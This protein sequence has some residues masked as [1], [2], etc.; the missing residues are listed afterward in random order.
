MSMQQRIKVAFLRLITHISPGRGGNLTAA[1]LP[2]AH[3]LTRDLRQVWYKHVD[4][5]R[6]LKEAS[7]PRWTVT[8]DGRPIQTPARVPLALPTESMAVAIAMEWQAQGK[9]LQAHTMPLMKLATTSIDQIPTIRPTM[10]SSMLRT[11]ETDVTCM[12]V[13]PVEEPVRGQAV[14]RALAACAWRAQDVGHAYFFLEFSAPQPDDCLGERM[15]KIHSNSLCRDQTARAWSF[16]GRGLWPYLAP[17]A[18]AGL[19]PTVT[20]PRP[21]I[22]PVGLPFFPGVVR[23][24]GRNLRP[25]ARLAGEG[26]R[27]GAHPHQRSCRRAL[28]LGKTKGRRPTPLPRRMDRFRA[29]HALWLVQVAGACTGGVARQDRRGGGVCGC[30]ASGAAPSRGMGG[31]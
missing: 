15:R 6:M 22:G 16:L 8:L 29:R 1:H 23:Q 26:R 27:R 14:S 17:P 20:D 10:H 2:P 21:P 18:H 24:G 13:E 31:G 12:R 3:Q 19:A 7:R 4:V 5:Q 28:S 11:M 25:L 9:M 30:K